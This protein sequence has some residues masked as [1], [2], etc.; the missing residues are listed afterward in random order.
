MNK[1]WHAI[2]TKENCEKKVSELLTKK[3]F[4]N[5]CP[6]NYIIK[7]N[8]IGNLSKHLEI[9]LPS[10][11]FVYI[12]EENKNEILTINGVI[13]FIYWRDKELVIPHIEIDNLQHF[14]NDYY[15]IEFEKRKD[16]PINFIQ[17]PYNSQQKKKNNSIIQNENNISKIILPSL[18]YIL[19][20][21]ENCKIIQ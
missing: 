19:F 17:D 6:L 8:K 20:S 3:R 9:L 21:K 16:K 14:L 1:K 10:I 2:Y 5:Y 12:E 13:N 7:P 4:S 18:G 15:N 11:V